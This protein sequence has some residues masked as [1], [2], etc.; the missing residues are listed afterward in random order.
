MKLFRKKKCFGN[1]FR[2][3]SQ[4]EIFKLII[5][6]LN[7]HRKTVFFEKKYQNFWKTQKYP[8]YSFCNVDGVAYRVPI[9]KI[10]FPLA[11]TS[12]FIET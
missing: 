11:E 8:R 9:I 5:Y 12:V 7:F 2:E 4:L 6:R 1:Q 10:E 3:V